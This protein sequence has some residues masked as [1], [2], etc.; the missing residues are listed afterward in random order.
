MDHLLDILKGSIYQ[1]LTPNY[2]ILFSIIP[3]WSSNSLV[4]VLSS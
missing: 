4:I 1:F 2:F 3:D